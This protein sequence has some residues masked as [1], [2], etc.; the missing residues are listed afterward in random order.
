MSKLTAVLSRLS[1]I[2][3]DD[4]LRP[5]RPKMRKAIKKVVFDGL[6]YEEAGKDCGVTKQAI[7]EHLKGM[8][9]KIED[10]N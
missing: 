6:T 5:K 10:R 7:Y 8:E 9:A 2:E 1:A 3:F 4:L